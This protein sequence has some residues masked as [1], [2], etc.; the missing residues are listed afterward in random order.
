MEREREKEQREKEWRRKR[1]EETDE[2]E[3]E[4]EEKVEA[5]GTKL[6]HAFYI[7]L[8]FRPSPVRA[9]AKRRNPPVRKRT[10]QRQRELKGSLRSRTQTGCRKNN[11][12]K[13]PN[14]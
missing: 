10:G 5:K 3:E 13:L 7:C 6:E 12:R 11:T 1:G 9:R 2:E 14:W 4:E 8:S